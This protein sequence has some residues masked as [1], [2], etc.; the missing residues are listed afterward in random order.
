M[1]DIPSRTPL[2][3]GKAGA[4]W[5][6]NGVPLIYACNHVS[7]NYLELLA[8]KG[9]I[10]ADTKWKLIT[11]E[12]Y[13]EIPRLDPKSLP[14]DWKMRPYPNSTQEIGSKWAQSMSSPYLM[15][16]SCRIPLAGYPQEHNLLINP[17]HPEF[18]TLVKQIKI[19][20]VLYEL[21]TH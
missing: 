9:S 14:S 5:N 19:E 15:V 10:V 16:P 12:V 4:R 6:P 13:G 2:G 1:E 17:L 21:N 7:L 8:I 3:Y 18:T 11:L 20:Q